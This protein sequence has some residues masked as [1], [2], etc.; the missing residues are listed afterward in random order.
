MN[1]RGDLPTFLLFVVALALSAAA[2]FSFASF[3]GSFTK[4]SDERNLMMSSIGFYEEYL[5]KESEIAGRESL[6][7]TGA[8]LP[9]GVSGPTIQ[10]SDEILKEKFRELTK[11]KDL[12]IVGFGNYFEKIESGDFSFSLIPGGFIFE[13]N[14]LY[15]EDSEGANKMRRNFGFK[16]S[17]DSVTG[18]VFVE[19]LPAKGL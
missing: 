3:N 7:E 14:D 8:I 12:G 1:K 5:I 17:Y 13:I 10:V 15:I 9:K 11:E 19:K 16:I 6:I 4:I 18:N 2:L